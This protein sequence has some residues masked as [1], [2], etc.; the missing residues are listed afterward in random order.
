MVKIPLA[1]LS[2][3]FDVSFS[4]GVLGVTAYKIINNSQT[5]VGIGIKDSLNY[6]HAPFSLQ[7]S[8]TS[9]Y[10]V[11]FSDSYRT[12]FSTDINTYVLGTLTISKLDKTNRIVAGVFNAK[13][14]KIGC[15]DTIRFTEGRF[16]MKYN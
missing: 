10:R 4:Q 3:D 11:Y 8:N 2:I 9:L 16:D 5:H 12:Y 1:F 6:Y 14:F 7:L 15:S 13:L